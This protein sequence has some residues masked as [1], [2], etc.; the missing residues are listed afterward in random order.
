MAR[1]A[2]DIRGFLVAVQATQNVQYSPHG[3]LSKSHHALRSVEEAR[4]MA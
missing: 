4:N 2:G 1:R 3:H